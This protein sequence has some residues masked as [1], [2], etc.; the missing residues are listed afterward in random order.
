MAVD[1]AI[2]P[3]TGDL[4]FGPNLD[5]QTV[6][7]DAV[8]A[9]RARVRLRIEQGWV[10]DPSDGLLGSRLR[11]ALHLPRSRLLLET[12]AFIEEALAPM[13]DIEI[14]SVMVNESDTDP[15]ALKVSLEI[16]PST[17]DDS[18]VVGETQIIDFDLPL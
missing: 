12:S 6:T 4:L 13:D 15:N 7:E 11:A 2:D 16:Q 9:Q 18:D 1:L 14:V 5:F 3:A 17:S 10:N 8:T